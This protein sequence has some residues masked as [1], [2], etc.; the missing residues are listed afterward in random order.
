M[1][2]CSGGT[3]SRG[4]GAF[5]RQAR[6]AH[7]PSPGCVALPA[8]D[9]QAGFALLDAHSGATPR[10]A[11][12]GAWLGAE[13][14][15]AL[16]EVLI[17]AVIVALIVIATFT[18]FDAA[19]RATASERQHNQADELAQQDEE[20]LRGMQIDQ[21]ASL[22]ETRPPIK[23][24]GT[25][26]T[27][28]SEG[29]F[30]NDGSGTSSCTKE[31]Q[32]A[33]YVR[34]ISKVTWPA[35][36]TRPPVVETGLIAPPA[37]G[38]LLVQVFDNL[39]N[40]VSGMYVTATGPAPGTGVVHATTGANGCVIFGSLIEG[41]YKVNATQTGFV[42]RD[43]NKEV[44]ESQRVVTVTAG[45][46]AKKSLE[47]AQGGALAVNFVT[48]KPGGESE[49]AEGDAVIA[50]NS[51]LSAAVPFRTFGAEGT[52]ATTVTSPYT[53]F[54]FGRPSP[55]AEHNEGPYKV[56]AG[57]CE[58]DEPAANGGPA[59]AEIVVVGGEARAVTVLLAKIN[60]KV[61]SG[62]NGSSPGSTIAATGTLT[63]TGCTGAP[64]SAPPRT[65]TVNGAGELTR[66]AMPFGSYSL[67]VTA[68]I[69]GT[70]RKSKLTIANNAVNG[71]STQTIYLG[72]GEV[73][74]TCP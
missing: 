35:L 46:T 71:T 50:D 14:G 57:L 19:N 45:A 44:P 11:H 70:A 30:I 43:G 15:F 60:I 16:L 28:T 65:I 66:P 42:D 59:A 53:L 72:A 2:P 25:E 10:R 29:E 61:W 7:S 31:A 18:G 58:A 68:S 22:K 6:R 56:Y 49:P 34:T 32:T 23:L 8:T 20:R 12:T 5:A 26:Y 69:A 48:H 67:C 39:G 27:V 54:P 40:P 21:I 24:N 33:S 41:E 47:F 62:T 63:D 4:A 1:G 36:G 74:A 73:G 13:T 52:Y 9:A 3:S 17:S 55:P 37:G 64:A 38:E 51:G